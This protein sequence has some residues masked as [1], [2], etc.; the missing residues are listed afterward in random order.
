IGIAG[1]GRTMVIDDTPL[2]D[3]RVGA[4]ADITGTL[5]EYQFATLGDCLQNQVAAR[6]DRPGISAAPDA[7]ARSLYP[8]GLALSA[9]FC[10]A[11]PEDAVGGGSNPLLR[12]IDSSIHFGPT[13]QTAGATSAHSAPVACQPF[14]GSAS[15]GIDRWF[16]S[17]FDVLGEDPSQPS[18]WMNRRTL[19]VDSNGT[20]EVVRQ[21]RWLP[22]ELTS[23]PARVPRPLDAKASIN[24]APF[25]DAFA[26]FFQVFAS[27]SFD[28]K[29]DDEG[30]PFSAL[31]LAAKSARAGAGFD[32]AAGIYTAA[33]ASADG[34]YADPYIGTRFDRPDP[35]APLDCIDRREPSGLA[36]VVNGQSS[37]ARTPVAEQHPL[38]MFR[39]PLRVPAVCDASRTPPAGPIWNAG[40]P[41]LPADQVLILRAA[42]AA[43]NL[44]AMRDSSHDA[45]FRNTFDNSNAGSENDRTTCHRIPLTALIDGTPTPIVANVYGL[46]RQP[47]ITEI[48]A[49]TSA[50]VNG[51]APPA[52]PASVRPNPQGYVAIKLFN[53]TDVA[54]SLRYCRLVG[55]H[56]SRETPY[57]NTPGSYQGM[58]VQPLAVLTAGNAKAT[59]QIDLGNAGVTSNVLG[60]I[61][62]PYVIPP[63]GTLVLENLPGSGVP[64]PATAGEDATYRPT[65]TSL[66]S[67]SNDNTGLITPTD[68]ATQNFAYVP[69]LS[70]VVW[71]RDLILMRPA[72]CRPPTASVS[73][74]NTLEYLPADPA[75]VTP[76]LHG[77]V[78]LDSYDF[79]GLA[80]MDDPDFAPVRTRAEIWHYV[81][82]VNA[83][84]AAAGGW[85]WVYP[86]RYDA[87]QSV[88]RTPGELPAPRQQGTVRAVG[89]DGAFG[90]D[91][92]TM[93]D[94]DPLAERPIPGVAVCLGLPIARGTAATYPDGF[95]LRLNAPEWCPDH[96]LH[97]FTMADTIG[98]PQPNQFPFGGLCRLADLLRVPFVGSYTLQTAAD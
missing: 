97:D 90:W 5:P 62:P 73:P 74:V 39:S 38:R 30:T 95:T 3:G 86:G 28:A 26:S 59:D 22:S 68:F 80:P 19:L 40:A 9:R 35:S 85:R 63:H 18:T 81:R 56:R 79:T 12:A 25:A 61:F 98:A 15:D 23:A 21:H 4:R 89:S 66:L 84:G 1:A 72:N 17:Q 67:S 54:I 32:A 96:P 42:L 10:L 93:P 44:E 92:H 6:N 49:N 46:R 88:P 2:A 91:P 57:A 82:S 16:T 70:R 64:T 50:G 58:A 34:F 7:H 47:Y 37:S 71:D 75:D 36:S 52:P 41:R 78:P 87:D 55:L 83:S 76:T 69:G 65:S 48:Y 14:T 53:P 20:S 51:A 33:G 43:A 45:L 11:W 60:A 29:A 94:K 27:D 13:S 24:T 8:E 77:M 31:F